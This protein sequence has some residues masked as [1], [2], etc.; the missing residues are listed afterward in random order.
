MTIERPRSSPRSGCDLKGAAQQPSKPPLVGA[1]GPCVCQED[2]VGSSEFLARA[3]CSALVPQD[4]CHGAA[5][6]SQG[7]CLPDAGCCQQHAVPA[8]P[9]EAGCRGTQLAGLQLARLLR[10][11]CSLR[12]SRIHSRQS[13]NHESDLVVTGEPIV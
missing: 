13:W 9:L 12:V 6:A 8:A 7:T 10:S 3:P 11:L 5:R 2:R 4:T 1:E